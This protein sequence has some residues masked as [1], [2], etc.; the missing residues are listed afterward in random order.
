[1]LLTPDRS[2][3]FADPWFAAALAISVVLPAPGLAAGGEVAEALVSAQAQS[4]LALTLYQNDLALVQDTRRVTLNKGANLLAWQ[5][6]PARVQAET[7]LLRSTA[8][9]SLT[10]LEQHYDLDLLTPQRLLEKS[11][12]EPVRIIRTHPTTGLDSSEY[13]TVLAASDGVVLKFVDRVETGVPGRLAFARVPAGL[14]ERPPLALRLDAGQAGPQELTLSYLT[15]GL[16]W[17]ADYVA[18]LNAR[19]D[20]LD[21][22]GWATLSNT[23]GAVFRDARLQLVAGEVNRV[24]PDARPV[25]LARAMLMAEAAPQ[26]E[27]EPLADYYRYPLPRPISLDDQQTKQVALLA[28]TA[29]PVRKE[30]VLR[31]AGYYYRGQHGDLGATKAAVYVEFDN[32]GE[33]LAVPLP[34]GIVRVYVKDGDGA[35]FVG[36][37][38]IDHTAKNETVRLKLGEAFDLSAEKKQTHFQQIANYGGRGGVIETAY[39]L[40]LRNARPEKVVVKVV[41]PL[42]GDW[43][44]LSENLPH[45]QENAR[46]AVW[47]VPVPAD[48]KTLLTWRVRVKY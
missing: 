37:D 44:I 8:G 28:A 27:A 4:G 34:K 21:L 2:A 43:Q 23:S 14:R 47:S 7:A 22:V 31:G 45:Q 41:E 29:L 30:Y 5:G 20:R 24:T 42:P 13:A 3:L 1:M 26:P 16:G 19:G 36:E 12:G 15:T 17:R 38:R 39:Q 35:Q 10:L 48:G 32:R 25:P 46:T 6:L 40:E 9:K 11:V 18:E 33:G